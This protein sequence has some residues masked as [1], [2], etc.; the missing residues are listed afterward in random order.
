MDLSNINPNLHMLLEM[1]DE[2][3]DKAGFVLSGV[4]DK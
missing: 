3:G 2:G 4:T 1:S